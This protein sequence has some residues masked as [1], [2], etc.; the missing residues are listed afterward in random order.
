[1]SYIGASGLYDVKKIGEWAAQSRL[2]PNDPKNASIV[3]LLKVGIRPRCGAFEEEEEPRSPK[4]DA[5]CPAAAQVTRGGEVTTPD[6]FRLEHLQEEFN[7]VS[8]QELDRSK[9]FRMLQLRNQ[10]VA[11]FR[12]YKL[13]PAQ[14]REVTDR[15]FQVSLL[16]SRHSQNTGPLPSHFS[17]SLQNDYRNMR[18][19][20]E[21][22]N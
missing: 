16:H 1:M 21:K 13:I 5:L 3:Q 4:R 7:F 22:E 18:Q 6:Y 12:N 2:D 9:R 19:D 17:E 20:S 15:M 10:G 11:E 14:E 8:D